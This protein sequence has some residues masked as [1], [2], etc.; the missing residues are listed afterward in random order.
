MVGRRVRRGFR[1]LGLIVA[2]PLLAVSA[3]AFGLA[4]IAWIN[5]PVDPTLDWIAI[6]ESPRGHVIF[7]DPPCDIRD[8]F[9]KSSRP[10][11]AAQGPSVLLRLAR[12][13]ALIA[14]VWYAAC[15]SI[16]CVLAGLLGYI[17]GGGRQD[18]L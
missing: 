1:W 11:C 3:G 5:A 18:H 17:R 7:S 9:F 12:E 10:I 4:G 13:S 2:V 6:I 15:W 16:G 14:C 8:M